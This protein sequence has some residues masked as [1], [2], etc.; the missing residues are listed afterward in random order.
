MKD[1]RLKLDLKARNFFSLILRL[2]PSP[3]M[4]LVVFFC[5][6]WIYFLAARPQP[7]PLRQC[8]PCL[9]PQACSKCQTPTSRT[10]KPD[11]LPPHPQV[12]PLSLQPT[13]TTVQ[14]WAHTQ[15]QNLVVASQAASSSSYAITPKIEL[16]DGDE[17]FELDDARAMSP[18]R[19][20]G[21]LEKMSQDARRQLPQ[22]APLKSMLSLAVPDYSN[23]VATIDKLGN[24]MS[25]F[26]R[27]PIALML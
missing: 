12:L 23:P 9:I 2:I 22:S 18:Q 17:T 16:E 11:H 1:S 13:Q 14:I 27:F 3:Y 6:C 4:K 24:F 7:D 21:D 25:L 19:T 15:D 10:S 26:S 20:S 8:H 5:A